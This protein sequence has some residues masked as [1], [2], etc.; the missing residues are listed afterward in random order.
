MEQTAEEIDRR[1]EER[2][3]EGAGIL[4]WP[5]ITLALPGML[6]SGHVA[7]RRA[8]NRHQRDNIEEA[9]RDSPEVPE[10]MSEE[11]S[12]SLAGALKQFFREPTPEDAEVIRGDDYVPQTV[13]LLDVTIIAGDG[14]THLSGIAI[15]LD[16][17]IGWALGQLTP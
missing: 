6:V 16:Q 11:M 7:S 17:V 3:E 13:Y 8:Y 1:L 14:V 5:S 12:G 10:D 2:G 15:E 4:R 9:A